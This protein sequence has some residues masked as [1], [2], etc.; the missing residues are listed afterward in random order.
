[1][2]DMPEKVRND[3]LWRD[4]YV[5]AETVYGLLDDLIEEHPEEQWAT[6]SK[7]RHA[8]NDSLFYVSQSVGS[9]T[10]EDALY[11]WNSARKNLFA[12]Q[13]M[14]TLA[15][16]QKYIELD[17]NVIVTIDN[18]LESIDSRMEDSKKAQ[19]KKE[20]EDLEPWLEKY[21]LWQKIQPS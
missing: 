3:S 20:K 5:L 18:I 14:Y 19:A 6:A 12:L 13:S 10:I 17:P 11:E 16:K 7:L 15:G 1:M 9:A 2:S 21:R 8:A 4:V